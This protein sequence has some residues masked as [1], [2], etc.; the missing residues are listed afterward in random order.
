MLILVSDDEQNDI[1]FVLLRFFHAE[2][3]YWRPELRRLKKKTF[4]ASDCMLCFSCYIGCF[5]NIL[6]YMDLEKYACVS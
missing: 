3:N 2:E 6:W 5:C 1:T 4:C